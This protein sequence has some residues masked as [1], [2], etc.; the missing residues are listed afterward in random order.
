MQRLDQGL[1]PLS[2]KVM[3]LLSS[4]TSEPITRARGRP[5]SVPGGGVHRKPCEQIGYQEATDL[6]RAVHYAASIGQ[7]PNRLVTVQWRHAPSS[8]AIPERLTRFINLLGQWLRRRT[9]KPAVWVYAREVGKLKGEHFHLAA[10]VPPRLW[11]ALDRQMRHWLELETSEEVR[12]TAIRSDAI[13]PGDMR[14]G[15]RSYFLKDSVPKARQMW[16]QDKH[17]A[18]GGVVQGKRTRVSHSIGRTA[19]ASASASGG[20]AWFGSDEG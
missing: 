3:G 5:R 17:K 2:D 12:H 10:H 8:R 9:G 13:S 14:T 19:R 1:E 20:L 11:S 7:E 15:V 16:V 18:T 6:V 4:I